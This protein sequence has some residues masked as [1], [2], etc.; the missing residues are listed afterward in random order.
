MSDFPDE[1]GFYWHKNLKGLWE[2]VEIAHKSYC[3]LM[4][5]AFN[6]REFH[7]GQHG[8]FSERIKSPDED[9]QGGHKCT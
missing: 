1:S 9:E 5:T 7:E 2:I 6:G 8:E 3:S 4:A